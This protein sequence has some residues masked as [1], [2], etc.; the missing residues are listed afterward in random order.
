MH[1]GLQVE[2]PQGR[3]KRFVDFLQ[4]I[5]AAQT[6]ALYMLGDIWDFWY[7]WKYTVPKGYV[8]V[9]GAL[10]DLMDKGVKVY[11]FRGNHDVWTYSYF[12][13]L[14]MKRLDQP[15]FV[16]VGGKVFCLGH[17]DALGRCPLGYRIMRHLFFSPF[18][19]R[20]FS[21]FLHPTVAM[22]FGRA[23]SR[24]NRLAR[25]EKYVWKGASEPL[26]E[27]CEKVIAERREK[28]LPEVERFVF[29]HFHVSA[30][31]TLS[32]GAVLVMLDSWI[33]KDDFYVY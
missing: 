15:A 14:G 31:Q 2:D 18:V 27:Y 6:D 11:F 29:G 8:R 32:S 9:L 16:D 17:G 24:N 22:A 7:E 21:I 28:G 23:W 10:M 20:C 4:G 3:E 12:E 30:R 5:P 1:L 33:F 26:V 25:R 13:E 19:Q